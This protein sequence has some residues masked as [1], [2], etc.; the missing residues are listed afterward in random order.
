MRW[1]KKESGKQ[2]SNSNN[3]ISM[4]DPAKW[5]TVQVAISSI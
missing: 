5:D 2:I 3:S 1:Y 4:F